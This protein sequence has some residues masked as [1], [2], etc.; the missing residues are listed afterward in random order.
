MNFTKKA[1]LFLILLL[2]GFVAYTLVST[3]Y[4]RT[5]EPFFDGEIVKEVPIKG[6]EDI[7]VSLVD[8]FA[9]ISATDRADR[10]AEHRDGGLYLMDLTMDNHTPVLL[11]E[12]LNFPFEPHGISFYKK[13]SVYH[14][15]AI[16]H[17]QKKHS[18]ELFELFEGKLEHVDS[19]TDSSMVSP[20]D[21][22]MIDESRFYFTNDHGYVKGINKFLEEYLGLAVSNVV[23][24]DGSQYVEVAD[25]IAYANGINF[26]ESRDLMF[27]SSP[28]G[29]LVNVYAKEQD[30]SL[31]FVE[32]IPCGTGV[33]N[34]EFDEDK[35]LWIGCHPSILAFSDYS[36][37]KAE[38][39]P[40][41]VIKIGYKNK[42]D[43][44]VEKIYVEDG[45]TMSAASV[46]AV[47]G[48]LLLVGN[49]M[50]DHFLVMD[51]H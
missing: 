10:T 39:A 3:G 2:L 16:N 31:S 22:V 14:V 15:M 34:I 27:V 46:A 23:Y 1:F 25:G 30:G 8:S 44:S 32:E 4:F 45:E 26:D 33:D 24:Y 35:N 43:Y 48:N 19:L 20:N 47:F 28:R 42:S 12:S 5:I 11:T 29:F 18:I 13:D 49:V 38:V 17:A 50:D 6:A 37:G 36:K 40:S 21:L 9:L 51:M 7:T 41:E